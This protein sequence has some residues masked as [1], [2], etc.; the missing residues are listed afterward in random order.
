MERAYSDSQ[1][2]CWRSDIFV[3]KETR[4]ADVIRVKSSASAEGYLPQKQST[5]VIHEVQIERQELSIIN[6]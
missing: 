4:L 5:D 6:S 1:S 2:K 3:V